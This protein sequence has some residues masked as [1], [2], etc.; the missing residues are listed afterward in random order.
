M[1]QLSPKEAVR[2][3]LIAVV[4]AALIALGAAGS[5]AAATP[6]PF[7]NGFETDT[8]GW[9]GNITRVASGTNGINSASGSFHAEAADNSVFTRWGG[10]TNEFP[11]NGYTT[12]VDIYLDPASGEANDTRFD[13]TSAINTPAGTAQARLRLQRRLLRRRH[14]PRGGRLPLRV[15]RQQQHR[16]GQLVPEEPRA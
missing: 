3:G 9:E 13:W 7:F 11:A 4:A 5:A 8:N 16:A 15:Q 2:P 14:W 12:A 6:A 1:N 10:Y